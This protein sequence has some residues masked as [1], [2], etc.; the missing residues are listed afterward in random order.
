DVIVKL[1]GTSEMALCGGVITQGRRHDSPIDLQRGVVRQ[2]R[3]RA[4]EIFAGSPQLTFRHLRQPVIHE[5]AAVRRTLLRDIEPETLLGTPG[6]VA[7]DRS[8]SVSA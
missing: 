3:R 8:G 1:Q 6:P 4:L 7:R 5:G 2:Q